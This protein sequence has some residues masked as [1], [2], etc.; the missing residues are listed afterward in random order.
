LI[1]EPKPEKTEESQIEAP[2]KRTPKKRKPKPKKPR[3]KPEPEPEK[4]P[5]TPE[6]PSDNGGLENEK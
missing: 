1:D 4:I 3:A 6:T 5:E 2:K